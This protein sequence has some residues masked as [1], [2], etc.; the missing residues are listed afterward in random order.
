VL[1]GIL[2]PDVDDAV[3]RILPP[4]AVAV[5]CGGRPNAEVPAILARNGILFIPLY[6]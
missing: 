4:V 1:F 6:F 3:K 5:I 2:I